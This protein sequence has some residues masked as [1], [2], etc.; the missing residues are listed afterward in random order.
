M[1]RIAWLCGGAIMVVVVTAFVAGVGSAKLVLLVTA[2]IAVACVWMFAG[3]LV[4]RDAERRGYDTAEEAGTK[5][6]VWGVPGLL[7]WFGY[8]RGRFDAERARDEGK[9]A[10]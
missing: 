4:R 2:L 8:R 10:S 9:P 1:T 5:V 7:W 3:L 6:I